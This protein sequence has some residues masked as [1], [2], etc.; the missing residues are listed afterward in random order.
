[1]FRFFKQLLAFFSTYQMT[2][3][4]YRFIAV[5]GRKLLVANILGFLTMVTVI[6]LGGFIITKGNDY[7]ILFTV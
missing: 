6:V 4:L 5:V 2:L 3:S 1:M 7:S